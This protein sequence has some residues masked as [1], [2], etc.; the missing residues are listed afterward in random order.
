MKNKVVY[1]TAF[2]A[3]PNVGTE[4]GL[5][6]NWAKSYLSKGYI[7]V[8]LTSTIQNTDEVSLWDEA[9]IKII[10]LAKGKLNTAPQ[11]FVAMTRASL[12]FSAWRKS[13]ERFL[14]SLP[15]DTNGIV[16]HISWGSARLRPPLPSRKSNLVSV[17]GPLGG[18]HIPILKGLT[19]RSAVSEILRL[20]TFL[21]SFV[22]RPILWFGRAKPSL[23]LTTNFQT[24]KFLIAKGFKETFPM[25]ADG[26]SPDS[27]SHNFIE[28]HV[29]QSEYQLLWAGRFVPT[30]RPDLAVKIAAE[31]SKRGHPVCL[32]MAGSGPELKKVVDIAKNLKVR[33]DFLGKVPWIEMTNRYDS[34]LVFL[35]HSMRDSSSPGI[36]E[37]ASRGVP[38]VGL[39]VSGAA[40][41]VPR[42]V[43]LGPN[44][45]DSDEEFVLQAAVAIEELIMDSSKYKEI[46]E[47]AVSFAMTQT[48]DLKVETV[49]KMLGKK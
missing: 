21:V 2:E 7:P 17:I 14:D 35:F 3:R 22:N 34:S 24:E 23:V 41:F 11:G 46:S 4:A 16:H 10:T 9:Q 49:M 18:G 19:F 40:D 29:G 32:Q 27:V 36:L 25:F 31:I 33:T 8:V 44:R 37:A 26:I 43:F 12:E 20:A 1:L 13:C 6:W 48:W 39:R 15:Q 42:D 47:Q 45:F 28:K 38:S 5:A 30:K